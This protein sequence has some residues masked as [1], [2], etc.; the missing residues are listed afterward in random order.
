MAIL[1]LRFTRDLFLLRSV[2]LDQSINQSIRPIARISF[3]LCRIHLFLLSFLQ[4]GIQQVVQ[5]IHAGSALF[6]FLLFIDFLCL[7]C[8]LESLGITVVEIIL[9]SNENPIENQKQEGMGKRQIKI[10]YS[11]AISILTI[12]IKHP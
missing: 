7:C 8:R 2:Q 3:T 1:F 5:V 10:T 12:R 6:S 4:T 9:V 11:C